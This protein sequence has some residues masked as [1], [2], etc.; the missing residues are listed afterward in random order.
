M[1]SASRFCVLWIKKT[2]RKVRMVVPVLMTSCQVSE[3][4]NSGPVSAQATMTSTA[5][6]K[7]VGRPT[8][9]E[10]SLASL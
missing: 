3:K 4:W 6:K 9:D 2:I 7:I 10:V 1:G 5:M 8:A